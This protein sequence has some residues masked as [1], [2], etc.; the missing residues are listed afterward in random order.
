MN[1]N[2]KNANAVRGLRKEKFEVPRIPH[3]CVS[4]LAEYNGGSLGKGGL[5]AEIRG[6]LWPLCYE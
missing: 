2:A 3:I 4:A 6:V 5:G 1:K